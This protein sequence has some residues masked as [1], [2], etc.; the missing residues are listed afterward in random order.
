MVNTTGWTPRAVLRLL[1]TCARLVTRMGVYILF[2]MPDTMVCSTLLLHSIVFYAYEQFTWT[3]LKPST[4]YL[5]KSSIHEI[6][7]LR[8]HFLEGLPDIPID[9]FWIR[10]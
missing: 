3:T 7:V 5:L 6:N 9:Y 2:Q 8:L 4:S 1:K 10:L